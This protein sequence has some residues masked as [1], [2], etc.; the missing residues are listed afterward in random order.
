MNQKQNKNLEEKQIEEKTINPLVK[1]V[2]IISGIIASFIVIV[3]LVILL[4]LLSVH[5]FETDDGVPPTIPELELSLAL[6]I[7]TL[8][9]LGIV[10]YLVY[11]FFWDPMSEHLEK[12]QSNVIANINAAKDKNEEADITMNKANNKLEN[13]KKKASEIISESK[14]E[15]NDISKGILDEAKVKSEK[16]ISDAKNQINKERKLMEK[17]IKQEI[18]LNSILVSEKIIGEKIDPEKNKK[19]INDL[20]KELKK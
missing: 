10:L 4:G 2:A 3:G 18:L 12:R 6:F 13:S 5:E 11:F 19:M 9:S 20:I 8:I 15:A 16:I 7:G 14:K 17:E 1:K